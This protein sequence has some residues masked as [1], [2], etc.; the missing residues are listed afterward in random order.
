MVA[1]LARLQ[2]YLSL[3]LGL[4]EPF[5]NSLGECSLADLLK[6]FIYKVVL[7]RKSSKYGYGFLVIV[8]PNVIIQAERLD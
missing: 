6:D 5:G 8:V 2:K 3:N 4:F 7:I 1:S